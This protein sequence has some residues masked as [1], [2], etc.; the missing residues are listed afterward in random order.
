MVL[1]MLCRTRKPRSRG[2]AIWAG[3]RFPVK[4]GPRTTA[5]MGEVSRVVRGGRAPPLPLPATLKKSEGSLVFKSLIQEITRRHR[6][7]QLVVP[8]SGVVHLLRRLCDE[9]PH[10]VARAGRLVLE[11]APHLVAV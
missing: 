7:Q 1:V 11:R 4:P 5:C 6:W 3:G 8:V 2:E 9:L 10:G